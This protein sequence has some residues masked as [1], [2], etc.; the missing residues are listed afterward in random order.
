MERIKTDE[1]GMEW[2]PVTWE[3]VQDFNSIPVRV[4]DTARM[5]TFDFPLSIAT[6]HALIT[7][8]GHSIISRIQYDQYQMQLFVPSNVYVRKP[9]HIIERIL[10]DSDLHK[11][12]AQALAEQIVG[13]ERL[14]IEVLPDPSQ[15]VATDD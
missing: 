9:E 15:E 7:P 1:T 2:W 3:E 6:E 12:Q 13:S 14:K 4:E 8:T 5:V 11:R 10:M